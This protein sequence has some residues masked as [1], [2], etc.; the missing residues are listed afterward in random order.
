MKLMA[1]DGRSGFCNPGDTLDSTSATFG[2]GFCFIK[3][4]GTSTYFD[5]LQDS[6]LTGGKALPVGAVVK[7][8]AWDKS[9]DNPLTEGDQAEVIAMD[10]SCWTTDSPASAQE[11]EVVESSQCDIIAGRR[12]VRGDGIVVES[13]TFNGL[14]NTDSEMQRTIE[15][16][17]RNRIIDAGGKVT[18]LPR[19]RKN[20]WHFF[21]YREMTEA[22]EVEITLFRKMFI[23]QINA[24]QPASGSIPFS[25]NYTTLESWQYE[26]TIGTGEGS[27]SEET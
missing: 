20:F 9:G 6:T 3:A 25:F 21:I 5:T 18:M 13:G 1:T 2:G 10:I 19:T 15:G 22:G 8:P 4:K 16:L 12:A 26:E 7:L 11:G 14:Y 24:G 27:G 17:F 23:P